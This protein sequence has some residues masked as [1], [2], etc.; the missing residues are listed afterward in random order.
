MNKKHHTKKGKKIYYYEA[1]EVDLFIKKLKDDL[2]DFI[3]ITLNRFKE[4]ELLERIKERI[5]KAPNRDDKIFSKRKMKLMLS[6]FG[7]I[8]KQEVIKIIEEELK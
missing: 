7:G 4:T 8:G 2:I 1:D 3:S 6:D 5:R